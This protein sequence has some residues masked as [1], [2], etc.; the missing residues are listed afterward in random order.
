MACGLL[1]AGMDKVLLHAGVQH[2]AESSLTVELWRVRR[3]FDSWSRL[4]S[5]KSTEVDETMLSLPEP[6]SPSAWS[7]SPVK[8]LIPSRRVS[9]DRSLQTAEDWTRACYGIII[10]SQVWM[11]HCTY[12][13]Y[14][15]TGHMKAYIMILK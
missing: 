8:E 3:R 11:L 14:Y 12:P 10:C 2:P 5:I 7:P 6:S 4:M 9:V 13:H 1:R 15:Q